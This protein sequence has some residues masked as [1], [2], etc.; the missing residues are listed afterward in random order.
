MTV[1]KR[2]REWQAGFGDEW[3]AG[4]TVQEWKSFDTRVVTI[5]KDENKS[6]IEPREEL[7]S[8]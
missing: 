3:Q 7:D 5:K 1:R 4:F 2:G 6:I 8:E